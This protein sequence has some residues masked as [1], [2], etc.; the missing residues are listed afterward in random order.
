M[1]QR[2][3]L[4]LPLLCF[5]AY[6]QDRKAEDCT[7]IQSP[8]MRLACFDEVF[9]TSE[10]AASAKMTAPPQIIPSAVSDILHLAGNQP[11]E[12]ENLRVSHKGGAIKIAINSESKDRFSPVMFL[13]CMEDNITYL[14]VAL[15]HPINAK[16]VSVQVYDVATDKQLMSN[17]WQVLEGGYLLH[18]GRGL[19]SIS[20]AKK[21]LNSTNIRYE[22]GNPQLRWYFNIDGLSTHVKPL[23]KSCTW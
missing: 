23:R 16:E 12:N 19:F 4:L 21:M 8:A 18:V 10:V 2:Y 22:I 5:A 11:V 17:R 13:G 14:Q 7:T 3:L 6:S 15:N 20:N 9:H 1:L